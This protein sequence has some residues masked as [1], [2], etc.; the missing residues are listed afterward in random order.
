M[1]NNVV[2]IGRTD[3]SVEEVANDLEATLETL[4]FSSIMW[5]N[6]SDSSFYFKCYENSEGGAFVNIRR[7]VHR[8]SEMLP[9]GDKISFDA[10]RY[11]GVAVFTSHVS[12]DTIRRF[13]N[14]TRKYSSQENVS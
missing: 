12:E 1:E 11:Q 2:Y 8:L 4:G 6:F 14:L 13:R 9:H 3:E 5:I 7:G 10:E